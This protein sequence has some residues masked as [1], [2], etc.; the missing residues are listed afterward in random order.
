LP[1]NFVKHD[2]D[3]KRLL[4]LNLSIE[5]SRRVGIYLGNESELLK[6]DNFTSIIVKTL[7]ESR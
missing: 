6:T 3:Q 7:T 1:F 4:S 2:L 5:W